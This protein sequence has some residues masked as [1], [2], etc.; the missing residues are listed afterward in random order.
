MLLP[1]CLKHPQMTFPP[2]YDVTR[3]FVL[4]SLLKDEQQNLLLDNNFYQ[5]ES[6]CGKLQLNKGANSALKIQTFYAT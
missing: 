5:K 3:P 1:N 6:H 4:A 2:R